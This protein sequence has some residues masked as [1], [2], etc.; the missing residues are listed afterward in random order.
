MEVVLAVWAEPPLLPLSLIPMVSVTF[1]VAF[2]AVTQEIPEPLKNVFKFA[3]LPEIV[4]EVVPEPETMTPPPLV[5][6]KVPLGTL[7]LEVRLPLPASTS[8]KLI[9]VRAVTTSS[10][11]VMEPRALIRGASFVD[12]TLTSFV[13]VLLLL[14][15][16]FTTKLIVLVDVFGVSE[17]FVYVTARNADYH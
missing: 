2:G 6:N 12:A 17:L 7:K 1:E 15:P 16:S 5:A 4:K 3:K 10:K 14:V 9:P 8:V 13:A 11:T